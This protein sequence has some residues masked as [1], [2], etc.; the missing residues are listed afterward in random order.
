MLPR[1]VAIFIVAL[2]SGCATPGPTHAPTLDFAPK[3]VLPIGKKIEYEVKTITVSVAKEEERLG[4][5]QIGVFGN[6]YESSFKSSL[7]D[8]LEEAVA[9]AAIFN[10]NSNKKI[11][12]SA[13]VMKFE[14][15]PLTI[16]FVTSMV[17]RYQLIDRENGN[18]IFTRDIDTSG[19][20]PFDYSFSGSIRYAEARNRA[21]RENITSFI[22]SLG[23]F[24]VA[25]K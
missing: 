21:V 22:S 8:A 16:S 18:L 17:V 13:K 3:D 15:R 10:D 24:K 4:Q 5:T 7:K 20:A 2:L 6:Q 19:S 25:K 12:L 9:K 23:E 11:S 14:T 1:L